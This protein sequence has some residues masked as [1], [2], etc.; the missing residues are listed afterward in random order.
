MLGAG[1]VRFWDVLEVVVVLLLLSV[2]RLLS[3]WTKASDVSDNGKEDRRSNMKAN[4]WYK[5][6]NKL[7]A[8]RSRF[9]G[10]KFWQYVTETMWACGVSVMA[11]RPLP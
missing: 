10:R 6:Y 11:A 4:M 3:D 1:P 8:W 9:S 7:T 2:V 5:F